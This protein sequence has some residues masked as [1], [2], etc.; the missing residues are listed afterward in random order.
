[1]LTPEQRESIIRGSKLGYSNRS[2][3]KVVGCHHRTVSEVLSEPFRP[4]KNPPK[5]RGRPPLITSP[6]RQRLKDFATDKGRH[7]TANDIRLAWEEAEG[8]SVSVRT[9]RRALY[10]AGLHSRV[11]RR[12]PFIN[13]D[14]KAK[15]LAWCR[16]REDWTVSKWKTVFFT[17]EK[18]FTQFQTKAH[19]R[20]WRR[21]GEEFNRDCLVS[22]VSRSESIMVWGGF[23]W[24]ECGPLF[25]HSSSVTGLVHATLLQEHAIPT[26]MDIFPRGGG[27]FQQD[28]APVHTAKVAQDALAAE[29]VNVLPWPAYSPDLNPIEN[30]WSMMETNVRRQHSPSSI[31]ELCKAVQIEWNSI[32][33]EV[34]RDLIESMP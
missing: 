20:V 2:I 27:V 14:N 6:E 33:Q 18:S 19:K 11:A 17:D 28:N 7:L 9:I 13:D 23:S 32:P 4:P 16:E 25:I 21:P 34:L 12:K 3:A 5:K 1:M 22:T 31:A 15:R 8:K 24:D 10:K 29:K 26:F 30:L